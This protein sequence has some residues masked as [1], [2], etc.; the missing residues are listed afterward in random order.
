M[1]QD[2]TLVRFFDHSTGNDIFVNPA[3]VVAVETLRGHVLIHVRGGIEGGR[4]FAVMGT[5]EAVAV[6]LSMSAMA[7][8]N[9]DHNVPK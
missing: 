3:H 2:L 4:T 5:T 6:R 8:S 7:E 9:L 1:D